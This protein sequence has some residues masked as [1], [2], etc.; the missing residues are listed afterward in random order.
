MADPTLRYV[1]HRDLLQRDCFISLA[2][3]TLTNDNEVRECEMDEIDEI[4][5]AFVENS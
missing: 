1:S 5:E 3:N 4:I 2:T